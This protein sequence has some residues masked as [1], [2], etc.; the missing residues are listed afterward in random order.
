VDIIW[1]D[2]PVDIKVTNLP[3]EWFDDGKSIDDAIKN[4]IFRM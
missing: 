3:K 4:P 2:Q 1:N